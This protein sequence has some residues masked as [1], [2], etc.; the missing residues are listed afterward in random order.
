MSLFFLQLDALQN[1]YLN[2]MKFLAGLHF[3]NF[4]SEL[5]FST[6]E[7]QTEYV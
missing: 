3:H 5:S 4:H 7:M 6:L 2:R 1:A